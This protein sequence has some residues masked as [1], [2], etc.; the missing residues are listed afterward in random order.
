[1]IRLTR[2]RSFGNED[3]LAEDEAQDQD[4]DYEHV[5]AVPQPSQDLEEE[6]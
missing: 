6:D 3:D 2:I 5:E 4:R 1:M